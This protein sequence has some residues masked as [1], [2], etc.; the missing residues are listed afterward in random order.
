MSDQMRKEFEAWAGPYGH[1]ISRS[2]I[3]PEDYRC[4]ET[5]WA[6][7]AWQAARRAEPAQAEPVAWQEFDYK[8]MPEPGVYWLTLEGPLY[9]FNVA[10]NGTPDG[11]DTGRVRRRTILAEL[12]YEDAGRGDGLPEPYPVAYSLLNRSMI[13]D[14]SDD[15]VIVYFIPVNEP[16][17]P[18]T[19]AEGMR[20]IVNKAL[21]GG[22]A[23]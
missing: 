2:E 11:Y 8:N 23:V 22:E 1:D 13:E 7:D 6:Y 21:A 19:G 18:P 15:E 4:Q 17:A 5:E 14:L 9:D 12:D 16:A 3:N 20:V 10:P